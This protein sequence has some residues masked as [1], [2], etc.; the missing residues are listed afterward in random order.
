MNGFI[1]FT[2]TGGVERRSRF[3]HQTTDAARDENSVVFHYRQRNEFEH[4]RDVVQAAIADYHHPAPTTAVE[5]PTN[6][7]IPEQIKKLAA[8]RDDGIITDAEFDAKK[9]ELLSRL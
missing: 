8:L 5:P 1:R 2:V 7:D 4:L 3:G 6:S 9:A